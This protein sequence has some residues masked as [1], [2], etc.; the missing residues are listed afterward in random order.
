MRN[1]F[2]FSLL[3]TDYVQL[4]ESWNYF[5]VISPFYRLYLID[6]GI[7]FLSNPDQHITLEK[8]NLYLI[9]SFTM[10]NQTCPSHLS[11]YYVHFIE[12]SSDGSSLFA[13][14]RKLL[15]IEA[16]SSDIDLLK[17]LV[18]INPGRDLRK[19]DNPKV[20]EKSNILK[21]FQEA[22]LH[23]G[24]STILETQGLI[25]VLLSRFLNC[26]EFAC[27]P[28]KLIP[29]RIMEAINYIQTH[30]GGNISVEELATRANLSTDHFSRSFFQHTGQRPLQYIQQKR[31][32]RAQFLILTTDY[33][34]AEI[35]A[36][37]GFESL[38]YFARI[39]KCT[40]GQTPGNYRNSRSYNI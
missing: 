25:Q 29:S 13:G 4:N 3:N 35:A 10:F 36:Q 21:G 5:N 32:D 19:S 31:I 38:S 33:T 1:R 11:Q 2:T 39:F 24:L 30:L 15:Q 16:S 23:I 27:H 14:S 37:T 9:P 20:Y 6:D 22:N 40:T 18:A 7:G 8:G 34:F 17:R 26:K 12:E 28:Q